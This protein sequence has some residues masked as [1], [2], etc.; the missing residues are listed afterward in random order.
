MLRFNGAEYIQYPTTST[1]K[2][3]GS[4]IKPT[5]HCNLGDVTGA[6]GGLMSDPLRQAPRRRR[7]PV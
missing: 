4:A 6:G 1:K 5:R 2:N 7:W 3:A